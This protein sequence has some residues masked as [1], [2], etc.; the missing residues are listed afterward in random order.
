MCVLAFTL[1]TMTEKVVDKANLSSNCLWELIDYYTT[2]AFSLHLDLG[3]TS[4]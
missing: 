1:K 4:K 2:F 3:C